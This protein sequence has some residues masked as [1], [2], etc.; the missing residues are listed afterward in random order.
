[1]LDLF[2]ILD[3]LSALDQQIKQH[4]VITY[5]YQFSVGNVFKENN[6]GQSQGTIADVLGVFGQWRGQI[7]CKPFYFEETQEPGKAERVSRALHV[8]ADNVVPGSMFFTGTAHDG[9]HIRF[10]ELSIALST[11]NYLSPALYQQLL[12]HDLAD[13]FTS[14]A[15]YQNAPTTLA[16]LVADPEINVVDK[17]GYLLEANRCAYEFVE[18]LSRCG[19]YH[20]GISPSA[21]RCWKGGA[22]NS[23]YEFA[24][25]NYS[26]VDFSYLARDSREECYV[27]PRI[28]AALAPGA[29]PARAQTLS[30]KTKF[31]STTRSI[32]FQDQ[33]DQV[34]QAVFANPDPT[35]EIKKSSTK[36]HISPE[37]ALHQSIFAINMTFFKLFKE[38][39]GGLAKRH[40][41]EMMVKT[42]TDGQPIKPIKPWTPYLSRIIYFFDL[43]DT[44]PSTSS[45]IKSCVNEKEIKRMPT[46]PCYHAS[47]IR[48]NDRSD[49][50]VYWAAMA[51][52]IYLRFECTHLEKPTFVNA[53]G[54]EHLVIE[55][56]DQIEADASA[57]IG[58]HPINVGLLKGLLERTSIN[59]KHRDELSP[60][61]VALKE[62]TTTPPERMAGMSG[63]SEALPHASHASLLAIDESN[64]SD[65]SDDSDDNDPP[66]STEQYKEEILRMEA[67]DKTDTVVTLAKEDHKVHHVMYRKKDTDQIYYLVGDDR[68]RYLYDGKYKVV[69]ARNVAKAKA[70]AVATAKAK[71]KLWKKKYA[72]GKHVTVNFENQKI[73]HD[74]YYN[75]DNDGYYILESGDKWRHLNKGQFKEVAGDAAGQPTSPHYNGQFIIMKS[76]GKRYDVIVDA[77]KK[78]YIFDKG[79]GESTYLT[80]LKGMFSYAK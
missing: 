56:I 15:L 43:L 64:D 4:V 65:V 32:L 34:F 2:T 39:D 52:F 61:V 38:L 67:E 19:L 16:Q 42:D 74:L 12:D 33:A 62:M 27:S 44:R 7:T 75:N 37:L 48:P 10:K 63:M 35:D 8:I 50:T 6:F 53:F 26:D 72:T 1:M 30:I 41:R 71:T 60:L 66:S 45:R 18:V 22:T 17:I 36:I 20:F 77:D 47:N 21:I 76:D 31:T 23:N 78:K 49:A 28:W 13:K 24:V 79:M 70:E 80:D 58:R 51:L 3:K 69:S 59:G 73:K 14:Y 11:F 57:T 9:E 29:A 46:D 55:A 54:G 5:S 40:K 68:K 25:G